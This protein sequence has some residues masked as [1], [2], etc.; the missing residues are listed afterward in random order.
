[1]AQGSQIGKVP[2]MGKKFWKAIGKKI[3]GIG[4]WVYKDCEKGLMQNNTQK[5]ALSPQYKKYK[6]NDM[7]RFTDKKRLGDT[8]SLKGGGTKT[9]KRR[10]F[11]VVGRALSTIGKP[12]VT[13]LSTGDTIGGLRGTKATRDGV[14]M[15]F[16]TRDTPKIIGNKARNYDVTGLNT[17]NIRLIKVEMIKQFKKNKVKFLKKNIVINIGK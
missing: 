3:G 12:Y 10:K 4:G 13:M 5:H 8:V 2:F 11:P 15:A 9:L 7:R 6:D 17:K 16:R 1:M 14:T